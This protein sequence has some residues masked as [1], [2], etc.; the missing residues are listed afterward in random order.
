MVVT[1]MYVKPGGVG[2]LRASGEKTRES[3]IF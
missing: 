2:T 3:M 1:R